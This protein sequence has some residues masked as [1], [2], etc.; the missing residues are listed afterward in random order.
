MYQYKLQESSQDAKRLML[1]QGIKK[2]IRPSTIKPKNS[3]Q[4]SSRRLPKV[5]TSQLKNKLPK[6]HKKGITLYIY[7]YKS[8]KC[9]ET[10]KKRNS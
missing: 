2:C 4:V 5:E 8:N 6:I 1:A 7:I 3:S 9:L 10:K